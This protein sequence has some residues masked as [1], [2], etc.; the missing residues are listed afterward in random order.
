VS[1]GGTACAGGTIE[2]T[3]TY[4]AGATVTWSAQGGTVVSGQGTATCTL[5][6][7]SNQTITVTATA[8]R[9]GC[10]AADSKT[11]AVVP[12]P[13]AAISAP[14]SVQAGSTGNVA[15]LT[16][17][18]AGTSYAWTVTN[19]T[20]TAGQGT[21]SLTFTAGALGT[22]LVLGVQVTSQ[23]GC[24]ASGSK[25]IGLV[26]T[27]PTVTVT[28]PAVACAGATVTVSASY[29]AGS[30]IRWAA[31][32]GIVANG[33]GTASCVIAVGSG[34][35]LTATAT[36]TKG[37]CVGTGSKSA[38]IHQEPD[39]TV[40]A[41][42]TVCHGATGNTASVPSAG[43]GASYAWGITNGT[44]TGGSG[45]NAITFTAGPTGPVQLTVTVTAA[46]GCSTS[47]N[48]SVTVNPAPVISSFTATPS[49]INFGDTSTLSFTLSNATSW[50]LS[51]A[52][53]NSFAPGVGV[54][55]GTFTPSYNA[56]NA[57]GTDT[58]TL[59]VIGPCGTT[60]QTVQIIVCNPPSAVIT[61]PSSVCHDS[62]GNAASVPDAGAGASYSWG[63]TNGTITGG[64]GTNA[65]TF[66]AGPTGPVQ[67]TVTVTAA[68][69]C[70]TSGNATVTVNPAPV[71]SSF[72]ATP[73]T[74]NGG[75]TSTLNFTISNATSW[76]LSSALG[77]HFAPG[78]GTGSGAFSPTYIADNAAGTDTVTLT[79]IGPCGTTTQTVQI[80][81]CDPPVA[82]TISASGP[83]TFCVGESVTLTA[84]G[85]YTS[86]L[87][88]NG[89]TT[90]SITVNS[91]ANYSV[92]GT[93]A[94][95]CQSPASAA[96]TVTVNPA[97]VI[98][99][100]TATPSTINGGEAT[101]LSFTISNATSW[102]LGGT[103]GN[104]ITPS[105]GS[106][107]GTFIS[108]YSANNN[109]GTDTVTLTVIGPCG[110]TTQ[111]VQIIVN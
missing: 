54:G 94:S 105:T 51:S 101:S 25:A 64:T 68:A 62:T 82:P 76:S 43:A 108:I 29:P 61:A 102:T 77:N 53:G 71:I 100:F 36:V 96:T 34:G 10:S 30:T 57:T 20:I 27:P 11:A 28:M 72:T 88:S 97:P 86:Y 15:S 55:N 91:S 109:T 78:S 98:S 45:T 56:D 92:Q 80:T 23:A 111:T 1:L 83:T 59:T 18:G 106:G 58:V 46:A 5:R 13:S 84:S 89:A 7:D 31:E 33:Q 87:W 16:D 32:G 48:A 66:S 73:S 4:T 99:S 35:T 44:I 19:G 52:L 2:A 6:V 42:T 79:V 9:N 3:A 93:N 85:G 95:G 74:I 90:P 110:T 50:S 47:G 67:L 104:G 8:T 12:S 17:Q 60:T 70:P 63:I 41:P 37:G 40:T 103:L 107:N 75:D 39:A 81:V 49:T 14:E 69:G 38:P 26:C 21:R 24:R 22:P 65:I